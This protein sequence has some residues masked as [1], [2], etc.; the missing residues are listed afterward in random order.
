MDPDTVFHLQGWGNSISYTLYHPVGRGR[1]SEN[2]WPHLYV[3]V[4]SCYVASHLIWGIFVSLFEVKKCGIQWWARKWIHFMR[5]DRIEISIPLDRR[6][7]FTSRAVW[8]QSWMGDPRV[9]FI[10][11][12]FTLKVYS[13]NLFPVCDFIYQPFSK[14]ENKYF[15]G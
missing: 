9:R 10:Y 11:P 12:I 7:S 5:E 15:S 2:K 14:N 3:N 6:S 8:C 4:T 1:Q 13:Y